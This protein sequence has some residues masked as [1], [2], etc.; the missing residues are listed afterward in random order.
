M[1]FTCPAVLDNLNRVLWQ[2]ATQRKG[3]A[4]YRIVVQDDGVAALFDATNA[5]IWATQ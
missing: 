1:L 4:P 2:S 3:T 5:R